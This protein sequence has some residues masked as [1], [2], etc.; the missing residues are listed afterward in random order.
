MKSASKAVPA[1][2]VSRPDSFHRWRSRKDMIAKRLIGLGGLMVIAAVLLILFYLLYVVMP[3]F[4][5]AKMSQTTIGDGQLL[6]KDSSVFLSL[7][8]QQQV[9]FR[10]TQNGTADFFS[11]DGLQVLETFKVVQDGQA[12]VAVADD[13]GNSGLVAIGFSDGR[14][15]LLHHHYSTD[16]SAGVELRKIVPALNYPYGRDQR[17]LMPGGG[18][19]GLAMSNCR[20]IRNL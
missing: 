3:L 8:E 15:K 20:I 4:L 16:F 12:V 13:Q 14:V 1:N 19:T 18:I 9:A 17:V 5:P 6:G 7:E 2:I 11:L 10:I